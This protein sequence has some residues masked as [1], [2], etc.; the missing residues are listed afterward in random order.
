MRKIKVK[1]KPV[2]M[3]GKDV[4][5]LLIKRCMH[6]LIGDASI[7]SLPARKYGFSLFQKSGGSL[8]RISRIEQFAK[9]GY[10]LS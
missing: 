1:R 10:F 8:L 4:T 3:Y 9:S 2:W 7:A 6:C 5:V